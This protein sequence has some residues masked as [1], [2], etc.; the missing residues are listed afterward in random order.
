MKLEKK[1][2]QLSEAADAKILG[3]LGFL[4]QIMLTEAGDQKQGGIEVAETLLNQEE[5]KLEQ[6][7]DAYPRRNSL[8]RIVGESFFL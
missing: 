3:N 4:D 5:S 7:Q 6:K 2:G 1:V 8:K